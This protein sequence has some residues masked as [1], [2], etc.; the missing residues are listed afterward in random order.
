MCIF[1]NK[2]VFFPIQAPLNFPRLI[3]CAPDPSRQPTEQEEREKGDQTTER[4]I[5]GHSQ[6]Y[7]FTQISDPVC[8]NLSDPDLK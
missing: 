2:S 8:A 6:S 7:Q 4:G 5:S 3:K 1:G